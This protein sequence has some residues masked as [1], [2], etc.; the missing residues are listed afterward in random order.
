[1]QSSLKFNRGINMEHVF[2]SE[3]RP[4]GKKNEDGSGET[5]VWTDGLLVG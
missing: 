2:E 4:Q 3:A 1:M 5:A